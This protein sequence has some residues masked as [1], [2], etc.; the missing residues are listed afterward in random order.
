MLIS[1]KSNC[2]NLIFQNKRRKDYLDFIEVLKSEFPYKFLINAKDKSI[3]TI[4]I[5]SFGYLNASYK[6]ENPPKISK[7]K[8]IAMALKN[9]SYFYIQEPSCFFKDLYKFIL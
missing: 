4:D 8:N 7:V 6:V 2:I 9:N 3:P 5:D 1:Y